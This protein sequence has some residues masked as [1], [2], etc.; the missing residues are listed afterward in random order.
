[1]ARHAIIHQWGTACLVAVARL[2]LSRCVVS[3]SWVVNAWV[4]ARLEE[5]ITTYAT[6]RGWLPG[7]EMF[8]V[9]AAEIAEKIGADDA[10]VMTECW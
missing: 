4:G 7:R 10:R 1:M 8:T 6:M 9:L 5:G 2:S 3:R